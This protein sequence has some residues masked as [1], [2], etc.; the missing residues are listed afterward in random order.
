[1][2][3]SGLVQRMTISAGGET[4]RQSDHVQDPA[5]KHPEVLDYHL[6]YVLDNWTLAG[7]RFSKTHQRWQRHY[8]AI[9]PDDPEEGHMVQVVTEAVESEGLQRKRIVTA[10][11]DSESGKHWRERDIDFFN[12]IYRDLEVRDA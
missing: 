4:W 2:P 6:A 8:M 7:D 3:A 5:T 9:V 11:R 12:R 10:F 1:M